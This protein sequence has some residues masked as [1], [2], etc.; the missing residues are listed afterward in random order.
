MAHLI[1]IFRLEFPNQRFMKIVQITIKKKLICMQ[2][3]KHTEINST[4]LRGLAQRDDS[5]C[6]PYA[7][8]AHR[9]HFRK[10][11]ND[12]F[13]VCAWVLLHH[14]AASLLCWGRR[15]ICNCSDSARVRSLAGMDLRV[16]HPC[17]FPLNT[18]GS[19]VPLGRVSARASD[20]YG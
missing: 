17:V 11:L 4:N 20:S 19:S 15:C 3:H 13:R 7:A 18:R 1:H 2:I 5:C 9:Y 8:S 12:I 10:R 16:V 14:P 6:L